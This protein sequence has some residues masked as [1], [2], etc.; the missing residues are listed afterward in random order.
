MIEICES[1]VPHTHRHNGTLVLVP[2]RV[3]HRNTKWGMGNGA[4][5]DGTRVLEVLADTVP[6]TVVRYS[7]VLSTGTRFMMAVIHIFVRTYSL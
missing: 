2:V 1:N 7:V 6:R 3:L 4:W 5:W